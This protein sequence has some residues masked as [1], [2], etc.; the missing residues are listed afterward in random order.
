MKVGTGAAQRDNLIENPGLRRI[1]IK[2][3]IR[4]PKSEIESG[5][6]FGNHFTVERVL[7]FLD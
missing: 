6:P 3:Q 7:D 2:S 4:N 1:K 5:V